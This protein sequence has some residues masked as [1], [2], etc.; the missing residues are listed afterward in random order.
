MYRIEISGKTLKELKDNLHTLAS[1]M[2]VVQ[3]VTLPEVSE[4]PLSLGEQL[5]Q[6]EPLAEMKTEF[7]SKVADVVATS[8][9]LDITGL[10]HDERIHAST[11]TKT[12]GGEW[13]RKRGVDDVT[14]NTVAAELRNKINATK[15]E[16]P[17]APVV[18][19]A[20]VNNVVEFV[21]N[22]E[23]PPVN[24]GAPPVIS[25][26]VQAGST[27]PP[28]HVAPPPVIPVAPVVSNKPA[29]SFA[30][31]L[32]NFALILQDLMN[33]GKIDMNWSIAKTQKYGV[34]F[35]YEITS[36]LDNS[37]GLYTDLVTE[38]LIEQVQ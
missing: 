8:S 2:L 30:M 15:I 36:N 32:Q 28:M 37:K 29:Y 17:P 12:V 25:E 4:A 21:P 31:F 5:M 7:T 10:P 20:P 6:P 16:I 27:V 18:D 13:K 19:V 9:D 38:G 26:V 34:K 22:F 23:A 35:L 11:K 14:F 3:T 24:F 33:T 1:D